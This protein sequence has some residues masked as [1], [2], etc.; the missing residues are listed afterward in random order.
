M[1]A[2]NIAC[3]IKAAILVLAASTAFLRNAGIDR[4][5]IGVMVVPWR[6]ARLERIGAAALHAEKAMCANERRG[7]QCFEQQ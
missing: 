1:L 6:L 4:L 5:V 2:L 3:R 7:G